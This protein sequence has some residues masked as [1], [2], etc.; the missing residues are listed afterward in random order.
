M[1]QKAVFQPGSS[2]PGKQLP[3]RLQTG[4]LTV[5]KLSTKVEK[6]RGK[7]PRI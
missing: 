3:D 4:H 2:W 6:T 5:Y 1:A 7:N